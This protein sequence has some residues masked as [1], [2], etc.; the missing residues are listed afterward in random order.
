[1][2]S[3]TLYGIPNC[4]TVKKA[5]A[6]FDAQGANHVFVD[7]KKTGV[8]LHRLPAWAD[9]VGWDKLI[10]RRGT[11][12]RKLG[13]T[14]QASADTPHGAQPLVL[15]MPSVIKRPVVEWGNSEITAGFDAALFAA[16][17]HRLRG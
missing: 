10:N 2:E 13:V 7:F 17:L 4:D 14:E 15:A 3:I 5:R 9:A 6:W 11:T 16:V 8:P 12:W 1:M